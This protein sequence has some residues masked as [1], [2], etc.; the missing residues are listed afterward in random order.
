MVY[1]PFRCKGPFKDAYIVIGAGSDALKA[2][3]TVLILFQFSYIKAIGAG[4]AFGI[5]I[6]T[7]MGLALVANVL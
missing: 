2:K 7:K 5:S 6:L 4:P 3:A 1:A